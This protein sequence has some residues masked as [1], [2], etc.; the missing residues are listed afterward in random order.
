MSPHLARRVAVPA[1]A[2]LLSVLATGCGG[3]DASAAPKDATTEDFCLTWV[4]QVTTLVAK[5]QAEVT[6]ER[7]MPSGE[8]VAGVFHALSLIHI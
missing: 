5:M 3:I 1:A 2:L 8:E 6:Q 4:R 7:R